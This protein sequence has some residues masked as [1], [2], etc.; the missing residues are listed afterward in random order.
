MSPGAIVMMVLMLGVV[1]GGFVGLLAV[2]MHKEGG[3]GPGTPP[4]PGA[5]GD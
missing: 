4:P 1:V 2:A 3:R 5:D